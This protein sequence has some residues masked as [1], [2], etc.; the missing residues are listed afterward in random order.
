MEKWSSANRNNPIDAIGIRRTDT[1]PF[2]GTIEE[3]LIYDIST[4]DLIAKL[5]TRLASL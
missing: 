3:I 4:A 1:D 2:D 5:N